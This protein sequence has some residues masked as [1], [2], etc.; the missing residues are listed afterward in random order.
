MAAAGQSPAA[1]NVRDYRFRVSPSLDIAVLIGEPHDRISIADVDVFGIRTVRIEGNSE[2]LLQPGGE[3][4]IYLRFPGVA[5]IAQHPNS[6]GPAFRDEQ[7]SIWSNADQPRIVQPIGKNINLE[8]VG[9]SRHRP[10]RTRDALRLIHCRFGRIW[11]WQIGE[12]NVAPYAW[13]IGRP[14]PKRFGAS[15]N[16]LRAARVVLGSS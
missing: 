14:I 9:H 4:F 3:Y 16:P 13:R 7:I 1:G 10:C 12:G 5:R 8:P 2:G 15:E 6:T 11:F